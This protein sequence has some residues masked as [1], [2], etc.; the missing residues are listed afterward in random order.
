MLFLKA[1]TLKRRIRNRTRDLEPQVLETKKSKNAPLFGCD[2]FSSLRSSVFASLASVLL[3]TTPSFANSDTTKKETASLPTGQ[4]FFNGTS[5]S[6]NYNQSYKLPEILSAKDSEL[7]KQIF[8]LQSQGKWNAAT[9]LI[10]K[11]D[12]PLLLGH[13]DFQRYMHPTAYR[14]KYL[15]LK[16]WMGKYSD[17]PGAGRVYKLALRR[18]PANYKYPVQPR[19]PDLPGFD[20][21][22]EEAKQPQAVYKTPKVEK[23]Y[24]KKSWRKEMRQVQRQIKRWVQRGN[25][26]FALKKL[27]TKRNRKIFD[28][29]SYAESLGVIARGYYRYHKDKEAIEVAR[30]AVSLS[31][32]IA[33]NARWWAGLSAW[34]IKDYETAAQ[35]FSGLSEGKYTPTDSRAAGAYWASRSYLQGGWPAAVNPMLEKASNYKHTFYGLIASQALGRDPGFDWNMAGLNDIDMELLL[36]IPAAKRALALIQADQS[37]RAETELR[38][39]VNNLPA[40]LS[41]AVLAF[42]DAA[43]LADLSYRLGVSIQRSEGRAMDAAIYPVPGWAPENGFQ[44]DKALIYAFV[45]QESRFRPRAKSSAGA[46]G[47]MQLMPATAGY[48]AKKRFK[49]TE[50]DKL[51]EPDYNLMLGQ[52]YLKH[53]LDDFSNGGNLFHMAAAYNGGPGNLQKWMRKVDYQDDPLLFIESL[54]SRET[55]LYIEHVFSNLWIY[56]NRLGQPAPT[57][58]AI[59]SGNWPIYIGLDRLNPIANIV[60]QVQTTSL[61]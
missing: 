42:A 25:V 49:G 48:M 26:T 8:E 14:S 7:Y 16:K 28:K 50:R 54:P 53:L 11:L 18:R 40:S 35:L 29:I 51:Y 9:K 46:R 47:L 34:R 21:T 44:I 55:R 58:E 12:D 31:P 5:P 3:L 45:R 36:R 20:G 43:G 10:K 1:L 60:E 19:N 2:V 37:H 39:F 17:H 4:E 61:N 24:K 32:E 52:K 13:V 22:E 30:R 6:T 41:K 38:R 57:L 56:R 23:P 33:D 15:E 59:L 27:D